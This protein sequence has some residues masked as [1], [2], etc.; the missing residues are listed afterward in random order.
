MIKL[1]EKEKRSKK[2]SDI[3]LT[4]ITGRG[5]W[6]FSSWKGDESKSGGI[7]MNIGIHGN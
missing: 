3:D 4:Y 7:L 1:K 2:I 5:N 6:Y